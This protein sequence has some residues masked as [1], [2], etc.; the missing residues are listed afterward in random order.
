MLA[1]VASL[2]A[3][4]QLPLFAVQGLLAGSLAVTVLFAPVV[5]KTEM[6]ARDVVPVAVFTATLIT[7]PTVSSVR[8][9]WLPQTSARGSPTATARVEFVS[10]CGRWSPLRGGSWT[11]PWVVTI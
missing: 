4:R 7:S 1:W 8:V 2:L 9:Y 10:L 3:L 5:L 11:R 6:R